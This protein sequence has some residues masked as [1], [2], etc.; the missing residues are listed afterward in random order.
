MPAAICLGK[1]SHASDFSGSIGGHFQHT[2]LG[3]RELTTDTLRH[4]RRVKNRKG[5]GSCFL[6]SAYG[7]AV[8]SMIAISP[9]FT[10]IRIF[11]LLY[12]EI[13]PPI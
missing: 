2:M 9:S 3:E 11:L 12:R 8:R 1:V 6:L 13:F 4:S 5:I 7:V 10:D